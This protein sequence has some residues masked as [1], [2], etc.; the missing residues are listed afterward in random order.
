MKEA[1]IFKELSIYGSILTLTM[2]QLIKITY[3]TCWVF[4]AMGS[5]NLN[6]E[7]FMF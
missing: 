2:L 5:L 6:D 7:M 3:K 4:V 1:I